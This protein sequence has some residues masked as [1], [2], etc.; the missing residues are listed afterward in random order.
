MDID[1]AYAVIAG[2][3]DGEIDFCGIGRKR[4][5]IT[6]NTGGSFTFVK[7]SDGRWATGKGHVGEAVQKKLDEL[8]EI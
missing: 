4:V 2:L 8:T 5:E 6:T 7:L 3:S 1:L